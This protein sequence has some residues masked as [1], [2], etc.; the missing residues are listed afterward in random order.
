MVKKDIEKDISQLNSFLRGERAACETYRQV[1]EKAE[2][3]QVVSSLRDGHESHL[4]RVGLLESHIR[5]L[6]GKP[7]QDAGAW[8]A[9]AKAVEGG[10]KVF[11]LSSAVSILEEGEDHGLKDYL[12]D[13]DE[14]TPASRELVAKSLLPEQ[15]RTHDQLRAL[16]RM[17]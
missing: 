14:L 8:G 7:S 17:V 13:R 15:R 9:F 16:Q 1:I 4:R 6:G 5:T 3:P 12:E 10:A 11:G 2:S